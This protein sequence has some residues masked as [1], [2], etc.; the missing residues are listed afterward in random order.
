MGIHE[1]LFLHIQNVSSSSEP[2][3]IQL[4]NDVLLRS[5]NKENEL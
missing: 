4:Q 2:N 1:T 5:S 3:K